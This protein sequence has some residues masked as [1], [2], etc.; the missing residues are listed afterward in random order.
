MKDEIKQILESM[1]HKHG[2]ITTEMVLKEATKKNSPLFSQF[3]WDDSKA[4][5]QY[6]LAEARRLIKRYNVTVTAHENKLVHISPSL[7]KGPGEYKTAGTVVRSISEFERAMAEALSR[8]AA[9]KESVEILEKAA[10]GHDDDRLALLAVSMRSI[11]TACAAIN[12]M[13]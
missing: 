4:A 6:R 7:S 2:L 8:L 9:A 3:T 12:K 5:H 11:E 13:H 10:D 1:L